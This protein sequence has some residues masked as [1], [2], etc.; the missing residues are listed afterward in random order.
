MGPDAKDRIWRFAQRYASYFGV[1]ADAK[2]MNGMRVLVPSAPRVEQ[3]IFL[4]GEWEP[5]FTRYIQD[6]QADGLIFLD[7]GANIG[8]F[9]LLASAHFEQVH[10]IEASP[11]TSHRLRQNIEANNLKNVVVYECAVGGTKGHIDF[12]QDER[13]RGAASTILNEYSVFEARVPI[14][15]LEDILEGVEWSRVRLIKIDVEGLEAPVLDSI[16]RLRKQSMEGLEVFVEFDP[17][18]PNTWSSI[19]AFLQAGYSAFVVQGLYDRR[20][21][22]DLNRRTTLEPVDSP[23]QYFCDLLLRREIV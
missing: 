15:P 12:Y 13:Q 17:S 14:A 21:Y 4:F 1:Q 2:L 8:Y 11:S 19:E 5:L 16:F 23:P 3:E 20:D 7:V 9:S 10:A 6:M 22:V 18:R